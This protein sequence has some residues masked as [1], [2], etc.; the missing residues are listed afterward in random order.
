MSVPAP[1]AP[2][3]RVVPVSPGVAVPLVAAHNAGLAAPLFATDDAALYVRR[4]RTEAGLTTAEIQVGVPPRSLRACPTLRVVVRAA[5]GSLDWGYADVQ[6]SSNRL[7]FGIPGGGV[8]GWLSGANAPGCWGRG[9]LQ[10]R[11]DFNP[12][13]HQVVFEVREQ[14]GHV[15][16]RSGPRYVS[17]S[18]ADA[19][20]GD[21]PALVGEE[22]GELVEGAYKLAKLGLFMG[23]AYLAFPLVKGALEGATQK[24]GAR[25]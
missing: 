13:Q 18:L 17:R 8:V 14:D 16:A 4:V 2:L 25:R 21:V 19:A 3:H 5:D 1:F 24:R 22:I 10:L 11:R 7:L 15:I 6:T 20:P 9:T 12:A 23:G